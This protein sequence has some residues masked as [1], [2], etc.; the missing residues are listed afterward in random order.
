MS[1]K[2][3]PAGRDLPSHCWHEDATQPIYLDAEAAPYLVAGWHRHP[4]TELPPSE[5][6]PICI[7][8]AVA[9]E[10][11]PIHGAEDKQTVP[12]IYGAPEDAASEPEA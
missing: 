9:I 8:A 6:P 5:L 1:R 7:H 12:P 2:H 10:F 11:P 4:A 3:H